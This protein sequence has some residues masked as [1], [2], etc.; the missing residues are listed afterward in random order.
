MMLGQT[1]VE[2]G[3]VLV[4]P[5]FVERRCRETERLFEVP[6]AHC[7]SRVPKRPGS[8]ALQAS[9]SVGLVVCGQIERRFHFRLPVLV[10][11]VVTDYRGSPPKL[12]TVGHEPFTHGER[13]WRVPSDDEMTTRLFLAIALAACGATPMLADNWPQWRGPQLNG[14]STETNLPIRWSKTE[15]LAWTLPLPAW[16]GSTPVVWRDRVFLNVA[17][18]PQVFLWCVDRGKG[19][20]SGSGRVAEGNRQIRKQNMSSPSPVTDGTHVWVMT[21]TG[22]LKAFD[23]DGKERWTR[24]IQDD[25]GLFGQLYGY[26]SSPLLFEDSLYVQVLHGSHTAE[27]SYLLRIDKSDRQDGLARRT[28]RPTR[29]RSRRMPT[30]RPRVVRYGTRSE[31]VVSGAD[32]VTGHDPA[33]GAEVWRAEGL[34]PAGDGIYRI[35]ASPFVHDGIVYAPTRERPM[36]ALKAGG[37]GD[38]SR[39]ARAVALHE[40][41]RRADAGERRHLRLR[42]QRSRHHVVPGRQDR[43]AGLRTTAAAPFDVY[44]LAD[45]RRRQDLRHERRWPDERRPSRSEVRSASRKTISRTTRSVLRR[46]R[47]GRSSFGRI[48]RCM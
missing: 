36:L 11:H 20:S 7:C 35:I 31:I 46:C 8:Q 27:P 22:I 14:P 17:E 32:V 10:G 33:T 19:T 39:I 3:G 24:D 42:H 13:G 12:G 28:R 1:L 30:R 6:V 26:G 25:Y 37:R 34:N 45:P 15:G 29:G 47:T 18:G 44:R 4:S 23:F 21:G 2:S 38:V 43:R 41:T 40:W 48:R 5:S 9:S 16:S